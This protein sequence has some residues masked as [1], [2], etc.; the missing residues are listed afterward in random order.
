G[1]FLLDYLFPI[2]LRQSLSGSAPIV[3]TCNNEAAQ[4]YWELAA[5]PLGY[6]DVGAPGVEPFLGLTRGLTR[7]LK[8]VLAP[9]ADSN[10]SPGRLV[11]ILLVAD[12]VKE[13]PLPGAREEADL[14]LALFDRVTKN[15]TPNRVQV[16]SLIGPSKASTLDVL[17]G[18]NSFPPFDILHY[19]GHCVYDAEHPEN[20]GLL[21]SDGDRLTANDLNRIDR[22]PK[23]V[24]ANACQSG[25]LPSRKDLSSPE[26]PATFAQ[27]F[28]QKGVA[29]FICT[30]WPI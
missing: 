25:V 5:Q 18:I 24:F 15:S 16:T 26:L 22:T 27:A 6:D 19:A 8:T 29:N 20:S 28:F 11:R 30:A 1:Q 12:T 14:L 4:V 9:A 3:L 7:Q 23:L 17:L 13:S 21:F 2:D 10:T